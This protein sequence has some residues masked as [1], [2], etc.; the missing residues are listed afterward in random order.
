[1]QGADATPGQDRRRRRRRPGRRRLSPRR[2]GDLRRRDEGT[3]GRQDD[4]AMLGRGCDDDDGTARW[5][6]DRGRRAHQ[7]LQAGAR[8]KGDDAASRTRSRGGTRLCRQETTGPTGTLSG[9]DGTAARATGAARRPAATG[10]KGTP[11]LRCRTG[12]RPAGGVG[13]PP[14][15]GDPWCRAQTTGAATMMMDSR[16][17]MGTS[18]TPGPA[19]RIAPRSAAETALTGRSGEERRE[20]HRLNKR[21]GTRFRRRG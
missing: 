9:G 20:V 17:M 16:S 13:S 14:R 7:G 18:M 12:R 10:T 19:M 1:M 11:G 2:G 8:A 15:R 5:R 6:R 4:G 3:R 21:D